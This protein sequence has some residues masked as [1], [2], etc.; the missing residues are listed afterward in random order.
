MCDYC[1]AIGIKIVSYLFVLVYI[2][3]SARKALKKLVAKIAL[4]KGSWG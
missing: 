2:N 4:G 3:I 1:S